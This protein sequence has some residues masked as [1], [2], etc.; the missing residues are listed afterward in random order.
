[1][2]QIRKIWQHFLWAVRKSAK[3]SELNVLKD[4]ENPFESACKR[5]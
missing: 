1:M 4:A 3:I 5:C 2:V